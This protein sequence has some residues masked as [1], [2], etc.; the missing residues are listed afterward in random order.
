[1]KKGVAAI[2]FHCSEYLNDEGVPDLEQRH[3]FCPAGASS[4]CKYQSD[5]VTGENTYKTKINI[6]VAVRDVIKPVFS[7]TD[8]GS[9]ALLSK[10]L[11]GL[12]QN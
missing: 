1:M 10:C 7:H 6:P 8:L 11:H 12:T 3:K 5:K 2:V 4:W 9:D